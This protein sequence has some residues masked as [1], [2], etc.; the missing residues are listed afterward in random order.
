ME[1]V[2]IHCDTCRVDQDDAPGLPATENRWHGTG[3]LVTMYMGDIRDR[4]EHGCSWVHPIAVIS[5]IDTP[6]PQLTNV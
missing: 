3:H 1:H 4:I 2:A 5:P 6:P